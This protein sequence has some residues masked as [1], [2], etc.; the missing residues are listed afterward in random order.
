MSLSAPEIYPTNT[1]KNSVFTNKNDR[2][3]YILMVY[4]K[5][6]SKIKSSRFMLRDGST[7]EQEPSKELA[8][9]A[10]YKNNVLVQQHLIK[11]D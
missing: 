9:L 8:E 5:E 3:T 1:G 2:L 10:R 4:I 6:R 7:E 11:R